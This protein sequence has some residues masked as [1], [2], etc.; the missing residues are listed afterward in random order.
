M[1]FPTTF[2][3]ALFFAHIARASAVPQACH[4]PT[5]H[6]SSST[7]DGQ[8][9]LAGPGPTTVTFEAF[10]NPVYEHGDELLDIT[11][12]PNL[13]EEYPQFKDVPLFPDIGAAPDRASP[14]GKKEC[15]AL[16]KLTNIANNYTTYF[17]SIDQA[18]VGFVLSPWTYY[19]KLGGS[20]VGHIEVIAEFLHPHV[21]S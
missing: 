6:E 12:C 2:I 11:A 3:V 13:A 17:T 7:L 1:I 5:T 9:N 4:D 20:S 21:P 8:Y 18:S 19:N 15:G 16:W 10:Y 14:S